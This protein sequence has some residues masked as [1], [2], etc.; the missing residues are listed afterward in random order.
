[1]NVNG[2]NRLT[3]TNAL[4]VTAG[5]VRLNNP[6]NFSG[7]TL[8]NGTNSGAL[9]LTNSLAIQNSAIDTSGAGKVD[10]ATLV[11]LTLG[12]LKGSKNITSLFNGTYSGLTSLTLNPG[13]G[14][15][16]TYSGVIADGAP[17]MALIKTGAGTQILNGVNTYTGPTT[18]SEG[19]L[20]L[21]QPS[22]GESM[23]P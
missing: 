16:H 14:K 1:M 10:I 21:G 7:D 5:K 22:S 8:I 13:A 19:T 23:P 12:G 9:Y 3:G 4:V 18:V 11:D 2:T 15:T 6:N 20:A 17:G